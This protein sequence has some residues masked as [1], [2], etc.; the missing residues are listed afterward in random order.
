MIKESV[1]KIDK[2]PGVD[3]GAPCR[4]VDAD[5]EAYE[6][7][8]KALM[9]SKMSMFKLASIIDAKKNNAANTTP[10]EFKSHD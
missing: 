1:V 7:P 10:I 9:S 3:T 4:A 5:N 6:S 8:L 2:T